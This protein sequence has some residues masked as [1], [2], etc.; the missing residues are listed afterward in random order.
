MTIFSWKMAWMH[1]VAV[2][3]L[4]VVCSLGF[5]AVSYDRRDPIV[6]LDGNIT[7]NVVERG[8]PFAIWRK[9]E[10]KR[11]CGATI[12]RTIVAPD[13]RVITYAP[14]VSRIPTFL[15]VQES[16]LEIL[17]PPG[18]VEG[19]NKMQIIYVFSHCGITSILWPLVLPLP[20]LSFIS[21]DKKMQ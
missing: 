13:N 2:T 11:A 12:H 6:W 8:A 9:Y 1:L 10:W 7:P 4:A 19:L 17:A 15:G 14:I 16:T 5:W 3:S 21:N 18:T 20:E